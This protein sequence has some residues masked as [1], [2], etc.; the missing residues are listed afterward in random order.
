MYANSA[1]RVTRPIGISTYGFYM[2]PM[3]HGL[4]VAG[5]VEIGSTNDH[6]NSK[7]ISWMK[8]K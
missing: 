4:R 8:K 3:T 6:V 5:T 1:H 7:R 2:T